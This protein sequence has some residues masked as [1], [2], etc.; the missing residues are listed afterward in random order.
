MALKYHL[1]NVIFGY[2][3][4]RL[5]SRTLLKSEGLTFWYLF[6]LKA[7]IHSGWTNFGLGSWKL[8]WSLI[9]R[10]NGSVAEW[11]KAHAWKACRR[12]TVSRVR[13]PV[14]PPSASLVNTASHN[15]LNYS[16]VSARYKRLSYLMLWLRPWYQGS[17]RLYSEAHLARVGFPC[18][19][20]LTGNL[21]GNFFVFD[22]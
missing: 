6:V 7:Y 5:L 22:L 20:E 4:Q 10:P 12:V 8:S 1:P 19:W 13:I 3:I 9:K 16:V 11:S 15:S 21:T 18:S 14:D 17:W 2:V